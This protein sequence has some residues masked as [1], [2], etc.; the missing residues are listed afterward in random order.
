M[1]ISHTER[2][3]VTNVAHMMLEYTAPSEVVTVDGTVFVINA[4]ASGT[5]RFSIN[6]QPVLK[7]LSLPC[8]YIGLHLSELGKQAFRDT[9]RINEAEQYRL[10]GRA[11]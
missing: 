10:G 8:K 3:N 2:L 7:G 9:I 5:W 4:A 11:G 1:K 6:R